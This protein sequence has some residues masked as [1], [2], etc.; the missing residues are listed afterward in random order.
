MA[1]CERGRERRRGG[2]WGEAIVGGEEDAERKG[3]PE[4]AR[5]GGSSCKMQHA[6]Q[7]PLELIL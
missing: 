1:E 3:H 6:M 7:Q 4:D 5:R 2:D